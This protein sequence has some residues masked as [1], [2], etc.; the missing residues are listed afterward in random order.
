MSQELTKKESQTPETVEQTRWVAAPVDIYENE[1]ELLLLAD[2]PGVTADNLKIDIDNNELTVEGKRD[3]RVDSESAS[4]FP[5]ANYRRAFTLPSGID[6]NKVAAEIKQ[7][8]LTL[9]LPKAEAIKPRRIEV[10]SG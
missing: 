10:H 9:H 3:E 7:G 4:P 6:H 1:D 8:V 2:L 5:V